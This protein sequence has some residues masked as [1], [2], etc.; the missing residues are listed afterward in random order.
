MG[1]NI[2][3]NSTSLMRCLEGCETLSN[4][5]CQNALDSGL[6]EQPVTR[7]EKIRTT[8]CIQSN[9]ILNTN[10]Q[11]D[12]QSCVIQRVAPFVSHHVTAYSAKPDSGVLQVQYPIF[13]S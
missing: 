3:I 5:F 13:I 9:Y 11:T 1:Y 7:S 4:L 2:E 6:A 12:T 8:H 10:R